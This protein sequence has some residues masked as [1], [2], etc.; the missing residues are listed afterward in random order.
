MGK[1]GWL[2]S[3]FLFTLPI[4]SIVFSIKIIANAKGGMITAREHNVANAVIV[5]IGAQCR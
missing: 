4:C 1:I 5:A 3:L 2:L